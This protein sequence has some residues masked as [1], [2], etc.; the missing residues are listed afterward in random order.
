MR[1]LFLAVAIALT[2]MSSQAYAETWHTIYRVQQEW[3]RELVMHYR[4][5]V[6]SIT[7]RGQSVYAIQQSYFYNLNKGRG[8]AGL[9]VPTEVN[10]R[11]ARITETYPERDWIYIRTGKEWWSASEYSNGFRKERTPGFARLVGTLQQ[12]DEI[13]QALFKFLCR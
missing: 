5:D 2:Q 12:N 8:W 7:R 10:C 6:A 11:S 1:K 3:A 13:Y 4:V 9:K